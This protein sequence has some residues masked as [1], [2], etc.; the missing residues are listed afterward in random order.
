[1]N[2]YETD[3]IGVT[4][5]YLDYIDKVTDKSGPFYQELQVVPELSFFYVGFNATR[6]P[7]D[8]VN[9]RRAFGQAIDKD[10]LR[11]RSLRCRPRG[12]R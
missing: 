11:S 9:L 7:F 6:P 10:K 2:M 12:E 3:E 1:M 5:V 4:S 8:D